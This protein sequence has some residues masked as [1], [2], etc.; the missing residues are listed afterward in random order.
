MTG[1]RLTR[2]I[3]VYFGFPQPIT[4]LPTFPIH[5]SVSRGM[6]NG[7]SEA[8]VAPGTLGTARVKLTM[9]DL[10]LSLSLIAHISATLRMQLLK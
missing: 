4:I 2:S 3:L 9:T 5:S 10:S 1:F 8:F 6:D 7:P